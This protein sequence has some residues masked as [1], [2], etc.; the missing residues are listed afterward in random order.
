M[1][2]DGPINVKYQLRV[3]CITPSIRKKVKSDPV[4]GPVWVEV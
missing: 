3:S 4:A 1:G 2:D